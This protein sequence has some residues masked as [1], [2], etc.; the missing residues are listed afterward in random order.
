MSQLEIVFEKRKQFIVDENT[1][2]FISEI[3]ALC[4]KNKSKYVSESQKQNVRYITEIKTA[5]SKT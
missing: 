4:R 2:T 5:Y 1:F 3:E